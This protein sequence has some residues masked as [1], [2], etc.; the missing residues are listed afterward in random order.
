MVNYLKIY[1]TP[2]A[3]ILK[4]AVERFLKIYFIMVP[5][6]G[7]VLIKYG[8]TKVKAYSKKSFNCLLRDGWRNFRS[9]LASI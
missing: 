9:A 1:Q 3:T 4:S 5:K 6:S 7:P 8:S 2:T